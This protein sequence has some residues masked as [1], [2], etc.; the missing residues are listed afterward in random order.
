[1]LKQ[2]VLP[3]C[4]IALAPHAAAQEPAEELPEEPATQPLQPIR[5][6]SSVSAEDLLWLLS[7]L[8]ASAIAAGQNSSGAPFIFGE[9]G[10]GMTFGIYTLCASADGTDCRGVEFMAVLG[11]RASEEEI[12]ALDRDY[13]AV[14]LYKVDEKTVHLSRYVILDHGVTWNNLVENGRVFKMLCRT[15]V[16]RLAEDMPEQG[17]Q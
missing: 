13:A 8:D 7:E 11:S 16:A 1:M 9:T 10:D 5:L 15:I 12:S 4:L 6:L 17:G 2:L 14:S 3:A